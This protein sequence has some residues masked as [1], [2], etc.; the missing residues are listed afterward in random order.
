M[1]G[2]YI[3]PTVRYRHGCLELIDQTLLPGREEIIRLRT[4]DA[5]VEAIGTLR[6]RGAPAIGVA[7]AY[8]L[9]VA[10]EE[11]FGGDGPVFHSRV[12]EEPTSGEGGVA[13]RA[14]WPDCNELVRALEGAAKRITAVRPTAANLSWA[15]RRAMHV[16][17]EQH[18]AADLL[19]ALLAECD[20]ILCED[21]RMCRALGAHGAALIG[22][23][24]S[25]LTHCN[26]GGLATSGFGTA[27]GIVFAA[28]AG[29]RTVRVYADETRPLLQGARLTAWEC[30]RAGI[31]VTV[32][33]DGAAASLFAAGRVDCVI[34]GADRIA[35]NG[36]TAN[37]VGTLAVAVLANRYG[38]PFYVA[39]PSST[40]DASRQSGADIPIEQRDAEEVL[41]FAGT[42]VAPG[43]INVYNPAF[44][45]TPANLISGII[46][47]RGVTLP[48]Y[49][50][51]A[52]GAEGSEAHRGGGA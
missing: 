30:R 44:D 39:A 40:I 7:G 11:A 1:S 5:V 31:P 43:D 3:I 4:V 35:A 18:T 28:V 8:G 21:L 14:S 9:L 27:L 33:V 52:G 47:E 12:P 2:R 10:I 6:V 17:R 36:D 37:K 48:P 38:V 34:V 26:T 50:F 29:G 20:A 45:V 49:A 22:D 23:G 41:Q 16:V 13:Q 32:L 19:R 46:T 42:L 24:S 51:C 15:V 25:I